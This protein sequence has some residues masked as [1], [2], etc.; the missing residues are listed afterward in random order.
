[1]LK[2]VEF[3]HSN[4]IIH[5]HI[6]PSNIVYNDDKPSHLTQFVLTDFSFAALAHP[7]PLEH[8]GS[9]EYIAPEVYEKQ[10]QTCA[11]DIWS[12]GVLTLNVLLRL[13][14]PHPRYHTF[15]GMKQFNWCLYM[16][17]LAELCPMP[18]LDRML[19]INVTARASASDILKALSSG[20]SNPVRR[21]PAS[22]D[23]ISLYIRTQLVGMP[24][25]AQGAIATHCERSRAEA[26]QSQVKSSTK[27]SSQKGSAL[28]VSASPLSR[29]LQ[30]VV[31]RSRPSVRR[32]SAGDVSSR[33]TAELEETAMQ[34]QFM[35]GF[36]DHTSMS[37]TDIVTPEI[38]QMIRVLAQTIKIPPPPGL[39]E[40]AEASSPASAMPPKRQRTETTGDPAIASLD[41][42]LRTEVPSSSTTAAQSAGLQEMQGTSSANL[43][44]RKSSAS[45]KKQKRSFQGR[46]PSVQPNIRPAEL[47]RSVS[48]DVPE[49]GSY[50]GPAGSS[51]SI[52]SSSGSSLHPTV[53]LPEQ[54]GLG[55]ISERTASS[56]ECNSV[57]PST[58]LSARLQPSTGSGTPPTIG[59]SGSVK[60]SEVAFSGEQQGPAER[61]QRARLTQG[62]EATAKLGTL[63][64]QVQ[65][66][67]AVPA[68]EPGDRGRLGASPRSVQSQRSRR[69]GQ[70]EAQA[71]VG[72]GQGAVKVVAKSGAPASR[73]DPSSSRPS[74]KVNYG[75]TP[76]CAQGIRKDEHFKENTRHLFRSMSTPD[77]AFAVRYQEIQ[78][79]LETIQDRNTTE[80]S[81]IASLLAKPGV[82]NMADHVDPDNPRATE[83]LIRRTTKYITKALELLTSSSNT[84][85]EREWMM[86]L[87]LLTKMPINYGVIP[88]KYRED[89]R[90]MELRESASRGADKSDRKTLRRGVSAPSLSP[91]PAPSSSP[92]STPLS[93]TAASWD[94]QTRALSPWGQIYHAF[95]HGK[96]PPSPPLNSTD[97]EKYEAWAR[98]KMPAPPLGPHPETMIYELWAHIRASSA[99]FTIDE[100]LDDEARK[101]Q[102]QL[103]GRILRPTLGPPP[104]S[105]SENQVYW[106][107]YEGRLPPSPPSTSTPR[108]TEQ[109][110][111]QAGLPR[112]NTLPYP[113]VE[114]Y[115]AW[116]QR[117]LPNPPI[118]FPL[119][120]LVGRD[121]YR[122]W[123]Q[124]KQRSSSSG[125]AALVSPSSQS[126]EIV[127]QARPIAR[128]TADAPGLPVARISASQVTHL[129]AQLERTQPVQPRP[130]INLPI[131]VHTSSHA[132]SQGSI[133]PP[134]LSSP[135][136]GGAQPYQW[137]SQAGRPSARARSNPHM[138]PVYNPARL[139]GLGQQRLPPPTRPSHGQRLGY[140]V[141]RQPPS[142]TML[143]SVLEARALV[144]QSP[145]P[146][147]LLPSPSTSLLSRLAFHSVNQQTRSQARIPSTRPAQVQQDQNIHRERPPTSRSSITPA[148][149]VPV[150]H[151]DP[152]QAQIHSVSCS[153]RLSLSPQVMKE[154]QQADVQR[155]AHDSP[156]RNS[157]QPVQPRTGWMTLNNEQPRQLECS[158]SQWPRLGDVTEEQLEEDVA[159]ETRPGNEAARSHLEEDVPCETRD[160]SET[161][162]SQPSRPIAILPPTT[163]VEVERRRKQAD[164]RR[165]EEEAE[166]RQKEM[167]REQAE[168]RQRQEEVRQRQKEAAKNR[169]ETRKRLEEARR[170]QEADDK[171]WSHPRPRGS[172]RR[173][174]SQGQ[175][176]PGRG[177]GR[178]ST[179]TVY[180]C[181]S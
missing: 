123:T 137:S 151:P 91:E 37:A 15:E 75:L 162:P 167:E 105:G 110:W 116:A 154:K 34:E 108:Q 26:G 104:A 74:K 131:P 68:G 1:M 20:P 24:E 62:E 103:L 65:A 9:L 5:R 36:L 42:P 124:A 19:K 77:L 47:R 4:G 64:S 98:A 178:L 89:D 63:S 169:E 112:H 155:A 152:S 121:T 179:S 83:S 25:E 157:S 140:Q 163:R 33:D 59:R 113:E 146:T 76:E 14:L 30:T 70:G 161:A 173:V 41:V 56:Q 107:W 86:I 129:H 90:A 49:S 88:A 55:Q 117:R 79:A 139:Y 71:E 3:I 87:I 84:A 61:A 136:Y 149:S 29:E 80:P 95:I 46:D 40:S 176:Q 96:L 93:P 109:V 102:E 50:T 127:R 58:V 99:K 180:G 43:K 69:S 81:A 53:P 44:R 172:F 6:S 165:R 13:P 160:R 175:V 38:Q 51:Q 7:P 138:S 92:Q 100:M 181:R 10:E 142:Q 148:H 115:R 168:T 177:R 150:P 145:P 120:T 106:T 18:H 170:K 119:P 114:I 97:T 174:H 85:F 72:A 73:S 28:A 122:G 23:F 133:M 8:C 143:E 32:G 60:S 57:A 11:V 134:T 130:G 132:S 118:P 158:S 159:T 78:K 111:D 144:G 48:F 101:H 17:Q 52:S 164:D 16:S 39:G 135:P 2:A 128:R 22:D 45:K 54:S 153:D 125:P 27:E 21:L 126:Q 156:M 35:K 12:L 67:L 147:S 166:E 94:P 66:T 82:I 141:R 31:S 171:G